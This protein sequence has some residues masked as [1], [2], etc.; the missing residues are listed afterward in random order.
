MGNKRGN[1]GRTPIERKFFDRP[2]AI[3]HGGQGG[4]G[5]TNEDWRAVL[6]QKGEVG[7]RKVVRV[8]FLVGK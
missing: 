2:E 5:G 8:L 6:E 3:L 4:K 7:G 1:R